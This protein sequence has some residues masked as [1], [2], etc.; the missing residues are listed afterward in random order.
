M[1][2]TE[3][4]P[5]ERCGREREIVGVW[6][7]TLGAISFCGCKE[8]LDFG[9]EPKGFVLSQVAD[10]GGW[11]AVVDG[12]LFLAVFHKGRYV[13]AYAAWIDDERAGSA[14]HSAR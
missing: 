11:D 2:A 9:A 14:E 4:R 5:C 3:V 7:S 1:S 8:C 13:P 12:A 10:L 6:S